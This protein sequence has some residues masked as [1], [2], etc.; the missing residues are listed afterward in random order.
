MMTATT[1]TLNS[2]APGKFESTFQMVLV[3]DFLGIS[4]EIALI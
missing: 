2:L 3:I 1:L 4:C